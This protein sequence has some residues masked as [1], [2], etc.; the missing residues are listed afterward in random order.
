MTQNKAMVWS[1]AGS[2]NSCGAG[3]QADN[4]TLDD[5]GVAQ[6]NIVT[7]VTAQN[8]ESVDAIHYLGG[9]MIERQWLMLAKESQAS[10]VKLGMLGNTEVFEAVKNKLSLFDGAVVCDPVLAS[11]S[12]SALTKNKNDY[13]QLLDHVDVFTPNQAEFCELFSLEF[14]DAKELEK[15][16]LVIAKMYG[17][18]LIVTGGEGIAK[19]FAADLDRKSV[20]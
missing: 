3:I 10:V 19:D 18:N 2:D 11:S 12:G 5:F 6:G 13:F 8:S 7:A 15:H 16:A 1:V 4:A 9:K 17:I 14:N 20:V